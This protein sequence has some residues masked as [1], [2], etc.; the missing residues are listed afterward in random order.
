MHVKKTGKNDKMK[1]DF[2]CFWDK[3]CVF[4]KC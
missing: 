1:V 2:D 4:S 3:Y